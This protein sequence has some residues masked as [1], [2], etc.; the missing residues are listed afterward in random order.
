MSHTVDTAV[1]HKT[2]GIVDFLLIACALGVN[3]WV[4]NLARSSFNI[5]GDYTRCG[6]RRVAER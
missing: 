1:S 2:R 4:S 6:G 5:V 3:T